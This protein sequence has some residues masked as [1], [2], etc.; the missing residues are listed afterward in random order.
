MKDSD[1]TTRLQPMFSSPDNM[2]VAQVVYEQQG[3]RQWLVHFIVA[4]HSNSLLEVSTYVC[5]QICKKGSLLQNIRDLICEKTT[6]KTSK[7]ILHT[8]RMVMHI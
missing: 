6:V 8:Y 2:Y 7:K 3:D 4:K 5:D 1:H